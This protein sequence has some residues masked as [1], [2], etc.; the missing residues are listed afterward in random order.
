LPA[1]SPPRQT[2]RAED[3]PSTRERILE[4]ALEAFSQLGFDGASTRA[5]ATGAGVNQGLIPYYFGTKEAL[6]REAV[7][8]A[9][10][11][12]REVMAQI[13]RRDEALS[14]RERMALMIRRYVAFV[15]SHPEFVRM[16][17]EEGKRDGPRTHWLVDRHVRPM[18][19]ELGAMLA[20]ANVMDGMPAGVETYHVQYIFV[21]AVATIFHQA[22]ECRL[23]TGR[24]PM[25]PASVRA[26]ADALVQMFLGD[27][28]LARDIVLPD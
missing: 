24:D 4:V 14:S 21:G 19:T 13:A 17:N 28:S 15:A 27:A 16:M 3:D 25:D 22:H 2:P 23:L 8:R 11:L 6:W 26:H 10:G 9:F 5:I 18:F 7:D 1:T 12:L 20:Q